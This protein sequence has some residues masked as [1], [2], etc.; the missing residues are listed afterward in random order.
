LANIADN[1]DN[2]LL[3]LNVDFTML[4]SV[5]DIDCI[6]LFNIEPMVVEVN[7]SMNVSLFTNGLSDVLLAILF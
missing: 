7:S 2:V 6:E 1:V 3:V 4:L 5:A